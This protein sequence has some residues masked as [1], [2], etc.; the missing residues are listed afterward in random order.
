MKI[1]SK[2]HAAIGSFALLLVCS[3]CAPPVESSLFKDQEED[4]HQQGHYLYAHSGEQKVVQ[5]P[6]PTVDAV[7]VQGIWGADGT[8]PQQHIFERDPNV[9]QDDNSQ[10]DNSEDES[11]T[12][13]SEKGKENTTSDSKPSSTDDSSVPNADSEKN[14][15]S[16]TSSSE[17]GKENTTSDSKPSSTDDSS[18]P[19]PANGDGDGESSPSSSREDNDTTSDDNPSSTDDSSFE[20]KEDRDAQD[21]ENEE[22]DDPVNSTKVDACQ[23]PS[24]GNFGST[25]SDGRGLQYFYQIET[26][27]SVNETLLKNVLLPLTEVGIAGRLLALF[28]SEC[29]ES[30][31]KR[32]LRRS[33]QET[34]CEANG[35][36]SLPVD[37]VLSGVPCVGEVDDST[38]NC[39]VIDGG[40]R[41]YLDADVCA[42]AVTRSRTELTKAMNSGALNNLDRRILNV[43]YVEEEDLKLSASDKTVQSGGNSGGSA[44]TFPSW[45]YGIIGAGVFFFISICLWVCCKRRK[46]DHDDEMRAPLDQ[47]E[48][49]SGY[50]DYDPPSDHEN[51]YYDSQE[52]KSLSITQALD[53]DS[54]LPPMEE[55]S[56]EDTD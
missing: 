39:F 20:E 26:A 41:L 11:S 12:S 44:S 46:N 22:A 25:S 42:D 32:W 5:V 15:E 23:V 1:P 29:R 4:V 54:M 37:R 38:R 19:G 40:A 43:T 49:Q 48:S 50:V 52:R 34:T 16:S 27:V 2:Q 56:G 28:F 24:N 18:F 30:T 53:D 21:E 6:T 35:F 31:S 47:G 45:A 17:K 36:S 7:R 9:R 14:E 51:P 13:S 55:T 8:V 10:D 33:L 3:H